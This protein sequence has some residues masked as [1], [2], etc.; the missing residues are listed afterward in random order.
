MITLLLGEVLKWRLLEKRIE[1]KQTALINVKFTKARIC[2]PT[3]LTVSEKEIENYVNKATENPSS[4]PTN[5]TGISWKLLRTHKIK[6][7]DKAI[8]CSNWYKKRWLIAE[9]F[10]VI[11]TKGF[12]IESSQLEDGFKLKKLLAITLE[13]ALQVMRLKLFL[14]EVDQKADSLFNSKGISFLDKVNKKI[15]AQNLKQKNI[16]TTKI[17]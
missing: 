1:K 10:R 4:I 7:F 12:A 16:H 6:N 8:E 5:K 13:V 2:A 15:A 17:H 14:N 3:G 9:L 11:K